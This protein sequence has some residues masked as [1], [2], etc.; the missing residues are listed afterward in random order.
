MS[1]QL[2]G[3]SSAGRRR[4][5]FAGVLVVA[6]VT[7]IACGGSDDA[8][9]SVT[10]AASAATSAAGSAASSAAGGATSSAP[11][12][13]AGAGVTIGLIT[14]TDSNPFFVSMRETA[15]ARAEAQGAELVALAGEFDGDNEGQVSAIENLVSQGV[16]GILITPNSS[17]G[18]LNAIEQ[19]RDQGILVIALDTATDPEDAVDAT[20]ATDNTK[21]GELQ[22]QWVKATLGDTSPKV[23]ML[24]GT[25][26]GTVDTFRHD[27]FLAGM[28]LTNDSPEILG[29]EN[30]N[31]DQTKAQTAMENL[32][33]RAP[34]ANALYTINEPAAAGGYQAI[35]SAGLTDQITIGSIDGSCT[36]VQNVADGIIGATVMQF[37]SRMAEQGVDAVI[38]FAADGTKPSGFN[39]TGSQL[40][41]DQPVDGVESEDTTWGAENCWG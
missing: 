35:E 29:M 19:A 17:T 16:D 13:D 24:D 27:G 30:T 21:A 36:G 32:L 40:I 20:F 11:D 18:I 2:S 5:L 33:Q 12:P 22:G 10:S 23:L 41:T 34:D 37:P 39:D 6:L 15:Q 3:P 7:T 4:S 14:K 25:P 8:G 9:S 26:G 28:G 31:G 1:L 38:A